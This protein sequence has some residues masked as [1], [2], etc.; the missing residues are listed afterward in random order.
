MTDYK[1]IKNKLEKIR[2]SNLIQKGDK[3][4]IAFSGGPD[5]VFLYHVLKYIQKDFEL[6]ISLLYVNHNLRTDV[7][8]DM[9]FTKEFSERN[10]VPFY[11]ESVNVNDYVIKN[12]KSTELSARELRYMKLNEVLNSIGYDKIATGHNLD[13]N[14][15]TII[16]RLLRGTSV[17]GLKGI[18]EKRENIIRPILEFEKK[19]ILSFLNKNNENY[20]TDYTNNEN[21][22]TRN[23]IR[24]ELFPMFSKINPS[25]RKKVS[26]LITEIKHT[27]NRDI[28]QDKSK[29][30]L[31]LLLEENEISL[32]RQKIDQIYHNFF[33]KNGELKSEGSKEFS[34]GKGKVLRKIY[35]KLEIVKK[36]EYEV[37]NKKINRTE[38]KKNQ[39]IEW[40]TYIVSY[41]ENIENFKKNYTNSLKEYENVT[42]LKFKSEVA[43]QNA[44]LII[45]KKENGDKIY[46]SKVGSQKV[47]KI[48][49]DQKISK[50]ERERIP[51]IELEK[52]Y[53]KMILAI[54]NI[55]NCEILEKINKTELEKI[56][57]NESILVI[58]RKDER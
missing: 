3:I 34:L 20:I 44:K 8:E 45:R 51:I 10:R 47:K 30:N 17:K 16:F 56:Q 32:S 14:V 53:K 37:N 35:N 57:K 5:S 46:I 38:L 23:Y 52:K 22:Y 25:F 43:I 48:F 29:K 6:K 33:E 13:D 42:F 27:E 1:N 7:Q 15:E 54:G 28:Q 36:N 12:K 26:E 18:P 21:D 50:W 58:R 40:Y 39:S 24:N 55:K 49:I 31:I 2:N 11:I 9:D 19:E 4:L 41:F